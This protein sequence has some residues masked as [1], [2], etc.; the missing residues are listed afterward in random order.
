MM[1]NHSQPSDDYSR[2][3]RRRK[4]ACIHII[5]ER[6]ERGKFFTAERMHQL[7]Q[8]KAG[9]AGLFNGRYLSRMVDRGVKPS[10]DRTAI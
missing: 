7:A 3:S 8:D 6:R 4:N 1:A 2:N 10:R 5:L 9:E